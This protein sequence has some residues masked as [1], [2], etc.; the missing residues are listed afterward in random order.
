[1]ALKNG[2][3]RESA[4]RVRLVL[5]HARAREMAQTEHAREQ[6]CY[7]NRM[8]I[9]RTLITCLVAVSVVGCRR[10]ENIGKVDDWTWDAP[11]LKVC[12]CTDRTK[13]VRAD[14][15]NGQIELKFGEAGRDSP[16]E[17]WIALD[18][19]ITI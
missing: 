17:I 12:T 7:A 15:K 5:E 4:F 13:R 9:L 10:S 2:R 19:S 14:V 8:K 3:C 16:L 11:D 18:K 1:M 6:D